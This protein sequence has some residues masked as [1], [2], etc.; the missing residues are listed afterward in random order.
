MVKAFLASK[1]APENLHD[2]VLVM[3]LLIAAYKFAG[4]KKIVKLPDPSLKDYLPLPF[5]I[6]S[7]LVKS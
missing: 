3:E 6:A 7:K 1:N 4:E 5:R 2:S